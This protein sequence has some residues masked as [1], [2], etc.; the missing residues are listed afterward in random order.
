MSIHCLFMI[1]KHSG[2]VFPEEYLEQCAELGIEPES[3][4]GISCDCICTEQNAVRDQAAIADD[5]VRLWI[6][7]G[8]G[9]SVQCRLQGSPQVLLSGRKAEEA[10]EDERRHTI[11][12]ATNRRDFKC[13]MELADVA[14]EVFLQVAPGGRTYSTDVTVELAVSNYGDLPDYEPQL[15]MIREPLMRLP[16]DEDFAF[17]L[18]VA[19]VG[20]YAFKRSGREARIVAPAWLPVNL[21]ASENGEMICGVLKLRSRLAEHCPIFQSTLFSPCPIRPS[22]GDVV[23]RTVKWQLRGRQ[24]QAFKVIGKVC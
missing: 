17:G 21:Q 16:C 8:S 14:N 2:L 15:R 10:K 23:T 19:M 6:C 7:N 4:N 11:R 22:S 3:I 1:E 18:F 20:H 12:M 24:K 5:E 13:E 9:V